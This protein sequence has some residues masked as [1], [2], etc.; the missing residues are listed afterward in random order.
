MAMLSNKQLFSE[1]V[2]RLMNRQDYSAAD[3]LVEPDVVSHN[4]LPGTPDGAEGLKETFRAFHAAFPD[5]H[6]ETKDLIA[7]GDRVA[8]RFVVTGTHRGEFMQ[9]KPTGKPVRYEEAVIVRCRNGRIVEHWSVADS[10][11]LMQAIG[12]T[13]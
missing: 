2:E 6:V 8:G 11:P 10:L 9:H 1:F 13:G 12:A 5:L 4:P 3:Q 7:E